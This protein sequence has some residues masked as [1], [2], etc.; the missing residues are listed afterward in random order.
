MILQRICTMIVMIVI[1]YKNN[2]LAASVQNMIH[3]VWTNNSTRETT[4]RKS[5][6]DIHE[7]LKVTRIDC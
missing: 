6:D 7:Q 3:R 1:V 4:M 5:S 2:F